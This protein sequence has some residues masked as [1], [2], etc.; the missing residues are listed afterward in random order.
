MD[1]NEMR[2][3]DLWTLYAAA[4][5]E[6]SRCPNRRFLIRRIT[7]V[8]AA[9]VIGAPAATMVAQDGA[10]AAHG[11]EETEGHVDAA[12]DALVALEGP[13]EPAEMLPSN[14]VD[15]DQIAAGLEYHTAEDFGCEDD[16]EIAANDAPA[17]SAATPDD[18]AIPDLGVATAELHAQKLSCLS[19]DELRVLYR[20]IIGRETSSVSVPYLVWKLREARKGRIKVGAIERAPQAEAGAEKEMVVLPL[21]MPGHEVQE[22]DKVWRQLG[23]ASRTAFLRRAISEY[24]GLRAVEG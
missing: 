12:D 19:V 17:T 20:Q 3:P 1:L 16:D 13:A 11:G 14:G 8:R 24:V 7:E 22:L 6:E 18:D 2:L 23:F 15:A 5:G 21:R 9:A 10:Q 4:V